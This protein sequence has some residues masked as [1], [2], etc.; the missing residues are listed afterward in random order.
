MSQ[1]TYF[2]TNS[3]WLIWLAARGGSLGSIRCGPR[4]GHA[5][6]R[7]AALG[8]AWR[9][10][11][12]HARRQVGAMRRTY[13]MIMTFPIGFGAGTFAWKLVAASLHTPIPEWGLSA[14]EIDSV[15]V[16]NYLKLFFW[17]LSFMYEA[18]FYWINSIKVCL[19]ICLKL[20]GIF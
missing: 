20:F 16:F 7:P 18:T 12:T 8:S 1:A 10:R 9:H 4:V 2:C 13:H 14:S 6:A 15:Q 3:D 5:R 19:L 17:S 11:G